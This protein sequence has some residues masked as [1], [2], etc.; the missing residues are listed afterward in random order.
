M[1]DTVI[2]GAGPAGLTAF[3]YST[4][5]G[6][7]VVCIGDMIGGKVI[8]APKIIDYPGI[9]EISGK[10]FIDR[11]HTQLL[12][13]HLEITVGK[14]T[15]LKRRDGQPHHFEVTHTLGTVE[16]KTVL[17]A[18]GNPN[19]QAR[20]KASV[21]GEMCE[22]ENRNKQYLVD[23]RMMTNIA[24]IFAAG[25]AVVY[26]VSFEQLATSVASGIKAA[27]GVY[28]YLT[29]KNPPILWGN[30]HIQRFI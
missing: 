22:V 26:P 20:N 17:L 15:E 9:T 2:I 3:L 1:K 27:G 16:T 29:G 19:K 21:L 25:D 23:L 8:S 4:M 7:E 13:S 30:T 5:Y 18:T 14:V 6:L 11:L 12:R 24:G 28:H 10:E